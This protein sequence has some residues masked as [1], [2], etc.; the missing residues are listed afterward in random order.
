MPQQT[1]PKRTP[2]I[3]PCTWTPLDKGFFK[4]GFDGIRKGN[5]DTVGYGGVSRDQ[6]RKIIRFYV[7]L[8]GT[9]SNNVAKMFAMLKGILIAKHV[10]FNKI[11]VKQ[12][13][14]MM[15]Q[16]LNNLLNGSHF[17]KINPI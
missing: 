4:I 16:I 8:M 3:N 2:S 10:Q 14:T 7:R 15:I 11:E 13:F 12:D 5:P 17:R 1:L 6:N 9:N